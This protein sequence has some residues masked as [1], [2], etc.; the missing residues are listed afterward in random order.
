MLNLP[1]GKIYNFFIDDNVFFFTDIYKKNCKFFS[2][3]FN[4]IIYLAIYP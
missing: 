4:L 2:S 1:D 3:S